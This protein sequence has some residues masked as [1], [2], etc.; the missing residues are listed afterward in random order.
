MS[1]RT[2]NWN[3]LLIVSSIII[4]G[5]FSY[6][7]KDV[8]ENCTRI[9]LLAPITDWIFS[10]IISAILFGHFWNNKEEEGFINDNEGMNSIIDYF[11]LLTRCLA[12]LY[13]IKILLLVRFFPIDFGC[14]S[15]IEGAGIAIILTIF[16]MSI[17]IYSQLKPIASEA[18]Y[19]KKKIQKKG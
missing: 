17:Y 12:I 14:I 16:I 4:L 11:F 15:Q 6:F 8:I 1:S 13:S 2:F 19:S 9:V 7:F 18:F 10:I 5:I 3:I